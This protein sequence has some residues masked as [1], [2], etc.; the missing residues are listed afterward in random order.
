[1]KFI[2]KLLYI[3]IFFN[4][5]F[6]QVKSDENSKITNNKVINNSKLVHIFGSERQV[7]IEFCK[8]DI[9]KITTGYANDTLDNKKYAVIA[10]TIDNAFKFK[11]LNNQY[12]IDSD[13][14]LIYIEKENLS[15]LIIDKISKDTLMKNI[16]YSTPNN[17]KGFSCSID[18]SLAL[19]GLGSQANDFNKR[20]HDFSLYNVA[21]FKYTYPRDHAHVTSPTYIWGNKFGLLIDNP[22]RGNTYSKK[23]TSHFHFYGDFIYPCF[24]VISSRGQSKITNNIAF[25]TGFQPLPPLWILGFMQSKIFHSTSEIREVTQ[26]FNKLKIPV[27]AFAIDYGWFGGGKGMGNFTLNKDGN[28][29]DFYDVMKELDSNKIKK[30]LISEPYIALKSH[31]YKH[32]VDNHFFALD[33]DSSIS[34]YQ[35]FTADVSLVDFTNPKALDWFVKLFNKITLDANIDGWWLD[36]G[37]PE[38]HNAGSIHFNG[39]MLNI[40]NIYSNI[41]CESL[42]NN[43]NI[44]KPNVRNILFSRAG[45][46]GIQKFSVFPWSGDCLNDFTTMSI[47]IDMILSLGVC[48]IAYLN[49]DIGGYDGRNYIDPIIYTRW[50]QFGTF[51]PI[52]RTHSNGNASPLPYV[53]NDTVVNINRKFIELRYALL[54]YNYTLAYENSTLGYPLCRAMNFYDYS[55]EIFDTLFIGNTNNIERFKDESKQFYFGRDILVA[56][57]FDSTDSKKVKFP[58]GDWIDYFNLNK[59]KGN[60]DTLIYHSL[61]EMPLFVRAGAIIPNAKKVM[62]TEEYSTDTLI[63]NYY[64]DKDVSKF[65]SYCYIDDGKNPNS[66]NDKQYEILSYQVENNDSTIL[67][68]INRKCNQWKD[69]IINRVYVINFMTRDTIDGGVNVIEAN[70]STK[71]IKKK[72]EFDALKFTTYPISGDCEI[73]V[74]K[75]KD[76]TDSKVIH[77]KIY[78]NHLINIFPNP[79]IDEIN[80]QISTPFINNLNLLIYDSKGSLKS[81]YSADELTINNDIL[82][83]NLRNNNQVNP[84]P[85]GNYI[86]KLIINEKTHYFKF[87]KK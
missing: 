48:G 16:L 58:N 26:S 68:K 49:S 86:G 62:N 52:M 69:S 39:H 50:L 76:A 28:W 74:S 56:P 42:I 53:Y 82:T 73:L 65:S 13:S 45:W 11:E 66:L 63:L 83:C 77:N 61:A 84:L 6:S 29:N 10:N 24:Y 23:H 72:N 85:L 60:T 75:I 2:L 3:V 67:F 36:V 32:A 30:L 15:M 80:I 12:E 54:P 33:K 27:D 22:S 9:A 37:E 59:Y 17:Y 18:S 87:I 20:N 40:H 64:Y 43:F 7:K 79:I 35:F 31:N 4:F 14:I 34:L 78:D 21:E 5:A 51:S 25:L 57:I 55:D 19:Y 41:W 46:S 70:K 44:I 8:K 1:M 47:Q 81:N 71:I 38:I